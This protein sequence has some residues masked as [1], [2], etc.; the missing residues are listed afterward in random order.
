MRLLFILFFASGS[1]AFLEED[2]WSQ[3]SDYAFPQSY[4]M[5]SL[6]EEISGADIHSL[7]AGTAVLRE[8]YK[9]LV[10]PLNSLMRI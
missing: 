8:E 3:E 2:V 7:H 1:N 10:S 5:V 9:I 6:Q 4:K